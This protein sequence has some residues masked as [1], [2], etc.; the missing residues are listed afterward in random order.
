MEAIRLCIMTDDENY[1]RTLAEGLANASPGLDI[2]LG[3]PGDGEPGAELKDR[4]IITDLPPEE[5]GRPVGAG[6]VI[7]LCDDR[8]S[9]N[10][11][12]P[13]Y[14]L[15]AFS[16]AALL[17]AKIRYIASGRKDG[18][19]DIYRGL[20]AHLICVSA[21]S[22]GAGATRVARDLCAAIGDA[23]AERAIYLSL[24]P[25]NVGT[26]ES[27]QESFARML[28]ALARGRRM[29]ASL[30]TR[31]VS[32]LWQIIVPEYN[33]LC[34]EM[35]AEWLDRLRYEMYG[36]GFTYMV[37]DVGTAVDGERYRICRAADALIS[38][39]SD[40]NAFV[41]GMQRR[42]LI[43]VVNR[44]EEPPISEE[45]LIYL[46]EEKSCYLTWSDSDYAAVLRRMAVMIGGSDVQEE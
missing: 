17:A 23:C 36:L 11:D 22:G 25:F 33:P 40:G 26:G 35:K 15:F 38:V 44:T 16:P 14:V 1:S 5:L 13:P 7:Q 41:G 9:E 43:R 37:I 19:S 20:R 6:S 10:T 45:D 31:K 8:A 39:A 29:D 24:T 42:G 34:S 2:L 30:L 32:G 28:Y 12:V 18:A 3:H 27:D 46:P 4:M 21:M